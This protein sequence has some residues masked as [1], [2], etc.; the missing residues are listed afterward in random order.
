MPYLPVTL[1]SIAEQTYRNHKIIAWEN[2]STDNTVEELRRWIPSRIPGVVITDRPMPLGP[3]LAAMVEM[4]DTELCA[5]IDA[6]DI[7]YPRRL[8]RQVAFMLAH[9]EAGV[10]GTQVTLIDESGS[11]CGEWNY[12]VEDADLRWLIRWQTL[13]C[14]PSVMFR[15][16]AVVAAGNY[17][18][19]KYEDSDLWIRMSL[20]TEMHNLPDKL[21][22]YRR[23]SRSLTGSVED[24]LPVNRSFATFCASLIFPGIADPRRALQLWEAT[25]PHQ[26]E[27][28]IQAKFR[29]LHEF[30][31]AAV[32]LARRTG[33]PDDYFKRTASYREQYYHL[34]RRILEQLGFRP[35]LRMR[36]RFAG[37]R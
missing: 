25:H 14:H 2:R 35:L 31:R 18:E 1:Q 28:P 16:S 17:R 29:H 3:R 8:E 9:P 21:L 15:K 27:S 36:Q 34:K 23:S 26:L 4:A 33:K 22:K 7:N 19:F 6:D 11:G 12:P 20:T 24:W 32:L 37:R 10:L 13:L 5:R 30:Q